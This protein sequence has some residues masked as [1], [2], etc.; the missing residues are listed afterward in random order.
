MI[1]VPPA[2]EIASENPLQNLEYNKQTISYAD[3]VSY[4]ITIKDNNLLSYFQQLQTIRMNEIYTLPT[5]NSFQITEQWIVFIRAWKKEL[6]FIHAKNKK[7]A[8]IIINSLVYH[9]DGWELCVTWKKRWLCKKEDG[10]ILRRNEISCI[11]S[12]LEEWKTYLSPE[13]DSTGKKKA[14]ILEVKRDD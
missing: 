12:T 4:V 2:Y 9:T 3:A 5:W 11:F 7:N 14:T 8:R 6:R 13:I 10:Q 1:N